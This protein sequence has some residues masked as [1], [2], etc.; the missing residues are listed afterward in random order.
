MSEQIDPDQR[1]IL[2]A[3]DADPENDIPRLVYADW[4]EE[5][6]QPERAEFIRVES[7]TQRTDRES[8][9]YIELLRR[10]DRLLVANSRRWF[11]PW[12]T[13]GGMAMLMKSSNTLSRNAGSRTASYSRPTSLRITRK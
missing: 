11:G 6:D 12:G 10:S 8:V 7:E 1:A 4:L 3:I 5:H 9:E 13:P 2:M